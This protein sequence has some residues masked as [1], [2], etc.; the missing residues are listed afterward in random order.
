M[1]PIVSGLL[2]VLMTVWTGF[3][4]ADIATAAVA[5]GW[6]D[7]VTAGGPDAIN[8]ALAIARE[9]AFGE[10]GQARALVWGLPMLVFAVI[11]SLT[12]EPA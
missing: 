3:A 8:Q 2:L 4:L 6:V 11:L 1:K 9:A 5:S 7:Q 10:A 12:A